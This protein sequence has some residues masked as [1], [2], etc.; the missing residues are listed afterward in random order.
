MPQK[1]I[2]TKQR[3]EHAKPKQAANDPQPCKDKNAF[4]LIAW[5][6]RDADHHV[7]SAKHVG[8]KLNHWTV[9]NFMMIS[10]LR[11]FDWMG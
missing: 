5:R 8:K 7:Q 11:E 10:P 2:K 3:Q 6:S 1:I 9:A 4:V